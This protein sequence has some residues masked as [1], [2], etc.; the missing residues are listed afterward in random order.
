LRTIKRRSAFF[1]GKIYK[2]SKKTA[3]KSKKTDKISTKSVKK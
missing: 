1:V 3:E 2:N